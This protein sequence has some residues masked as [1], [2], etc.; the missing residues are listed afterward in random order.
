MMGANLSA[1]PRV[2]AL[3]RWVAWDDAPDLLDDGADADGCASCVGPGVDM[4][5]G[6]GWVG[7]GRR[8]SGNGDL[9]REKV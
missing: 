2:Y 6:Y 5:G 7:G 8:E 9:I 1:P 3:C 4:L